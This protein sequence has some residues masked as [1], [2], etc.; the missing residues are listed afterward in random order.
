MQSNENGDFM[1]KEEN[2]DRQMIC[3]NSFCLVL[4]VGNTRVQNQITI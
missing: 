3:S 2:E 1:K 4:G